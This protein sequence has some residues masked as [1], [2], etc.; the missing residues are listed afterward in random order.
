MTFNKIFQ[1]LLFSA[2]FCSARAYADAP[3]FNNI[4]Q[5]DLDHVTREFSEDSSLHDVMPPSSLGSLFGFEVGLVGGITHTPQTNSVVQSYSPSTTVDMIPH[6]GI[7]GAIGVPLGFTG[8]LT[9]VPQITVSGVQYYQYAGAI[10][11]T[12]TDVILSDL[13]VNLAVRGYLSRTNLSFGDTFQNAST[14]NQPVTGTVTYSGTVYGADLMVSPKLAIIE[15][16]LAVGVI[17][18]KGTLSVSADSGTIFNQSFTS[19]TSA[20]S[21]S[22]STHLLI[23]ANMKLL[24]LVLGLEYS[25]AFDTDSYTAK[26]SFRF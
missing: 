15:P 21:S 1:L 10:K 16:Y 3:A 7:L 6:A 8:E 9:L 18:G 25:R 2:M 20:D 24:A 19:A 17:T 13:P 22:N 12:A 5:T 26:L 23:G 11:W 14:S 4:T